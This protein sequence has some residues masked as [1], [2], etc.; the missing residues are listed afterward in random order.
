MAGEDG[1][2]SQEV[3]IQSLAD[4]DVDPED[5]VGFDFFL[6]VLGMVEDPPDCRE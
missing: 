3:I 1:S 2:L 5:P 4:M 6:T